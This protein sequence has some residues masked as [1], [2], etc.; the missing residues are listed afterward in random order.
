MQYLNWTK[1]QASKQIFEGLQNLLMKLA[2]KSLKQHQ[3]IILG[4]ASIQSVNPLQFHSLQINEE[5]KINFENTDMT[6]SK[7]KITFM[8]KTM[9]LTSTQQDQRDQ[10]IRSLMINEDAED[11]ILEHVEKNNSDEQDDLGETQAKMGKSFKTKKLSTIQESKEKKKEKKPK[12]KITK[13]QKYLKFGDC[14]LLK[15]QTQMANNRNLTLLHPTRIL[16]FQ[17]LHLQLL[18]PGHGRHRQ[19]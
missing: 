13:E 17:V 4:S 1:E 6:E 8:N 9:R 15:A 18:L 11:A 7:K 14:V 10:L 12:E 16:L 5:Q 19:H 2:L 3:S